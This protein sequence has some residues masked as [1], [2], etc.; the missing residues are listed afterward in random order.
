ME[1]K[2]QQLK[3]RLADISDL[4]GSAALLGWDQQT[5]MPPGGA[6][7]RGNQQAVVNRVLQEWATAPEL[8]RLLEE[9]QPYAASLDPDFG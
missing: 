7:A 3:T 1:E 5:Y 8:G 6:E 9:L 2:L 4:A